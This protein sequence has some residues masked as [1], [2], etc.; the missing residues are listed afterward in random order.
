MWGAD[1]RDDREASS[2]MRGIEATVPA[3]LPPPHV[4]FFV[5]DAGVEAN[6]DGGAG[7]SSTAAGEAS[8]VGLFR[9]LCCWSSG[10]SFL[11]MQTFLQMG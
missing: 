8:P 10:S 5:G 11:V 1:R 6:V 4:R 9:Q 7:A 3:A 2:D